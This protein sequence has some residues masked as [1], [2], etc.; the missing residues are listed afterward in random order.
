MFSVSIVLGEKASDE[1]DLSSFL[2]VAHHHFRQE[3]DNS[4]I[5][6]HLVSWRF[7]SVFG[8]CMGGWEWMCESMVVFT[9]LFLCVDSGPWRRMSRAWPAMSAITTSSGSTCPSHRVSTWVAAEL[10]QERFLWLLLLRVLLPADVVEHIYKCFCQY[11]PRRGG[12]RRVAVVRSRCQVCRPSPTSTM[13]RKMRTKRRRHV[14]WVEVF[15]V[16]FF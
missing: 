8:E 15:F 7:Y 11:C 1:E 4:T 3:E 9:M 10:K 2:A 12:L 14:W 16:Y 6:S 5:A 13:D